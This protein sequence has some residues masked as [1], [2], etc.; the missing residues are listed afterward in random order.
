MEVEKLFIVIEVGVIWVLESCYR[1]FI[2]EC[3]FD[4][5][6]WFIRLGES[7]YCES[8]MFMW[9]IGNFGVVKNYVDR[10]ELV[11]IVEC[12]WFN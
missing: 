1:N 9:F 2:W 8:C 10:F 4:I 5:S 7:V 3:W 12:F 6:W 11:Y